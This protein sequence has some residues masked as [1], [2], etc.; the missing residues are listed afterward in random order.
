VIWVV[1]ISISENLTDS[2]L[3]CIPPG[4]SGYTLTMEFPSTNERT[5]NF[6]IPSRFVRFIH[7]S[8]QLVI[9]NLTPHLSFA[10]KFDQRNFQ[11]SLA[12]IIAKSSKSQSLSWDKYETLIKMQQTYFDSQQ[13]FISPMTIM[14]YFTEVI[15]LSAVIY[16]LSY[17]IYTK[18]SVILCPQRYTYPNQQPTQTPMPQ[19]LL[20]PPP[21]Y[22]PGQV[23]MHILSNSNSNPGN[24]TPD[25]ELSPV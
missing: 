20:T 25:S 12:T 19:R 21:A 16:G 10:D 18:L 11:V 23:E 15:V 6:S 7:D 8:N 17:V 3:E 1:T 9:F 24:H 2:D 22:E 4:C 14:Q 5:T 13:E